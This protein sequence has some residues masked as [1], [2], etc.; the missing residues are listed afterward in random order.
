[1]G[2]GG[3]SEVGASH[4][5]FSVASV[6]LCFVLLQNIMQHCKVFPILKFLSLPA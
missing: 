1:M 5:F 4:S 3:E 2:G 6:Y